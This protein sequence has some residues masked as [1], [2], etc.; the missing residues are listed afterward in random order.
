[1][2]K[3]VGGMKMGNLNLN[4]ISLKEKKMENVSTGMKMGN[5]NLNKIFSRKKHE[6]FRF[7]YEMDSYQN[8][9]FY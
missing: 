1:M 5:L 4:K 7:W 8:R 3:L 2:E 9:V 6:E